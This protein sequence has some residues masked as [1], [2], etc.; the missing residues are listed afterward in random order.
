M[1]F[2]D[3]RLSISQ[4]S[5]G[6]RNV[7]VFFPPDFRVFDSFVIT[8]GLNSLVRDVHARSMGYQISEL[9]NV[10]ERL[11]RTA[12]EIWSQIQVIADDLE[13][14]Q[15]TDVFLELV[16]PIGEKLAANMIEIG[17]NAKR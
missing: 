12:R 7:T 14:V 10:I 17:L 9:E 13:L 11:K 1:D 2:S 5:F 16:I 3:H 4:P 8:D 6:S 15:C